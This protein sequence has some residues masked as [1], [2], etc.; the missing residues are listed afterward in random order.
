MIIAVHVKKIKGLSQNFRKKKFL[1]EFVV[2]FCYKMAFL[3]YIIRYRRRQKQ[4]P[5][6][7]TEK[8]GRGCVNDQ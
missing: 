5:P 4:S 1:K 7:E 2:F 3:D 6:K 8:P